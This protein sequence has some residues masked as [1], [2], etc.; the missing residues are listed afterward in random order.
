MTAVWGDTPPTTEELAAIQ[1]WATANGLSASAVA[2]DTGA[3]AYLL[4]MTE[5]PTEVPTL[6]ITSIDQTEKG[7]TVTVTC[8]AQPDLSKV[9]GKLTVKTAQALGEEWASQVFDAD[10]LSFT[11]EGQAVIKVTAD[12]ATFMKAT[13][14]R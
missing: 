11:D 6:A 7:W 12:G 13:L 3:A 10:N 1:S 5:I 14:T 9:N 4:G 2:G 8:S